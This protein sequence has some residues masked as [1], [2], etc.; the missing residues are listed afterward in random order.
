MSQMNEPLISRWLDYTKKQAMIEKALEE[1]LKKKTQLSASEYY[2]LYY[3]NQHGQSMRLNDLGNYLSLSQSALSRLSRR[4]EEKE[5][6]LIGRKICSDD[7]RGIYVGLTEEG[8]KELRSV[9]QDV[10]AILEE[11]FKSE[12]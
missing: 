1:I 5:P 9:Q 12:D 2:A 8:K 3:L 7:K 6:P 11:Y 10:S 4:L